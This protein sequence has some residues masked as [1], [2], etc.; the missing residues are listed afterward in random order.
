MVKL[1]ATVLAGL[2]LEVFLVGSASPA[3]ASC[4]PALSLADALTSSD[5]VVVGTVTTARSAN[6]IASV[7]VEDIWRGDADA[8]IEVAGGPDSLSGGTSVD[9]TYLVGQRYLFFILEP[10]LH[11]N[12]GTFGARYEDNG[13]SDTRPYTADLEQL[14]PASARRISAPSTSPPDSS[15]STTAAPVSHDG[16]GPLVAFVIAG[17][18]I[19]SALAA[20]GWRRRRRADQA[21]Q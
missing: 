12:A 3:A 20:V 1:R 13:C 10:G 17:L 6:R 7:A 21:V 8:Q 19:C 18:L 14:R 9:R 5:L 4:A 15:S 11:G 16:N 2:L